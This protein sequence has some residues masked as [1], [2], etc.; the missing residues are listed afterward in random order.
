VQDSTLGWPRVTCAIACSRSSTLDPQNSLRTQIV[1]D[2][3]AEL[4]WRPVSRRIRSGDAAGAVAPSKPV[5]KKI[6]PGADR[7]VELVKRAVEVI[8]KLDPR[9]AS[10]TTRPSAGWSSPTCTSGRWTTSGKSS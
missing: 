8:K 9:R 10:A 7:P 3:F 4:L 5:G 1:S 2:V 6:A